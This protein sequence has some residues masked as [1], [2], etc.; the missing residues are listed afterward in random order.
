MCVSFCGSNSSIISVPDA[1]K[2]VLHTLAR[3]VLAIGDK[4]VVFTEI[5]GDPVVEPPDPPHRS[6]DPEECQLDGHHS[7]VKNG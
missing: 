3:D 6:W 4:A 2:E 1:G 7:V 5:L